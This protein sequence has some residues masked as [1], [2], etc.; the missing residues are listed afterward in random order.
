MEIRSW[1]TWAMATLIALSLVGLGCSQDPRK[2]GAGGTLPVENGVAGDPAEF[3]PAAFAVR[4]DMP[5]GY[6][7]GE[8]KT[9]AV[10]LDY[11]G[12]EPVTA[13]AVEL[14]LPEA[15]QYGGVSGELRPAIEPPAGARDTLTFV[16]IKTPTFPATFECVLD[17]PAE[18]A[19]PVSLSAQ[20]I[21]RGLGGELQSPV[22]VVE[23]APAP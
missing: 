22:V 14:L 16:W 21:Y 6:V 5:V 9:V 10:T 20:A 19:G 4:F 1:M 2:E 17:T 3:T 11:H 12:E 7:P 18:P 23:L 8:D 13:L 15:W